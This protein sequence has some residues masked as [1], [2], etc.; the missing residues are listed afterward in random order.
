MRASFVVVAASLAASAASAAPPDP[1]ATLLRA[2]TTYLS[3][4]ASSRMLAVEN[5]GPSIALA[6]LYAASRDMA[7]PQLRAPLDALLD[8][9]LNT[10][11][12]NPWAA[13]NNV[14]IPL[15]YSIGDT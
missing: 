15:G 4:N 6:E 3:L 14:T 11:G 1:T 5:Y 13:L 10:P 9:Q 7:L 8:A 12:S 2:A